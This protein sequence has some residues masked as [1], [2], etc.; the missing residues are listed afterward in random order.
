LVNRAPFIWT[1]KQP[2][3]PA[4]FSSHFMGLPRRDDGKNRWFLFRTVVELNHLPESM[5]TDVT[6][7]GRYQLFVNNTRVARGPVRCTP[8]DQKYDSVDIAPHLVKGRNAIG[9]IVHVFG[10]D[11]S[12]YECVKGMW[13]PTFGDGAFWLDNGAIQTGLDW[14]CIE[15]PAWDSSTPESNHGLSNIESFNARLFPTD[16]LNPDFDDSGWD[17]VQILEAGGGGP[18]AP[19]GGVVTR[20]FPHLQPSG[21]PLLSEEFIAVGKPHA[22]YQIT[23]SPA[24][25]IERQ[26]YDEAIL[27]EAPDRVSITDHGITISTKDGEATM[28]LFDFGKLQTGTISFEV[29]AEAG[30]EIDIA[31][32]EQIPGEWDD[33]GIQP[34]ARITPRPLLGKDAHLTRYTTRHGKQSFERFL[35]QAIKWMQVTVRNAPNGIVFRKLGVVQTNYPVETTGAFKSDDLLLNQ[36]WEAGAETLKLCM[37]DGWEDCPSR[38]QRQ[39]LGDATVEQLVGQVAF[40]PDINALNAKYL[41]DAAAS[42]RPDGLTQMFAPGNHATNGILIPDW[43][44]QWILNA[45]NHLL[46]SGD[47]A[48]IDGVFPSIE[49]ALNWFLRLLNANGLVA[50]MPYWHF[51]DWAGLGR[52]GEACALNAQLAGCLSA[53]AEMAVALE[54]PK[55][56]KQYE[57]HAALICSALER[58]WD[59]ARGIY[60]DCIDPESGAREPRTSQHANAAMILW[61]KAPESRWARMIKR[62]TD[63]VRLTFT[64]AP[65]IA[66]NGET[67]DPI[68]GVVQAN[69]FYSHFVYEALAKAGRADLALNQMRAH[70]GPMLKQGATTLWESFAPTASLCHGFSASPTY[71]LVTRILGLSPAINGFAELRIAPQPGD[72]QSLSGCLLTVNGKIS[73]ELRADNTGFSIDIIRPENL[74]YITQPPKGF[75]LAQEQV[76]D[77]KISLRFTKSVI[78]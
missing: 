66:P 62:V 17:A 11:K 75:D 78:A 4:G 59:E 58:H 72:L 52:Q 9:A 27:C 33:Q 60:V 40:G 8:L 5:L 50:D 24:L 46:W 35:W 19:F 37:H 12:W 14:R 7:D 36:L 15:C 6:A 3:N 68:E 73:A 51:M 65:P 39:W 77:N 57:L 32:A 10:Q 56:A 67:L 71:Y 23:P 13:Q 2:I 64:A 1:S 61:G 43:T 76:E 69:T 63:P 25:P 55:L 28:L 45:R 31:V 48:T 34:G 47:L 41:K 38:E 16:W 53:A 18:E 44:L 20:P 49:K 54:R 21:I 22:V 30:V 70:Y 26:A 29:K 42:Q 74:P